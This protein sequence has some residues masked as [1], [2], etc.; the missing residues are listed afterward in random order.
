VVSSE[1]PTHYPLIKAS[2]AMSSSLN[3]P[4]EI[5]AQAGQSSGRESRGRAETLVKVS[6]TCLVTKSFAVGQT[7]CDET[8]RVEERHVPGMQDGPAL[9]EGGAPRPSCKPRT[10]PCGPKDSMLPSARRIR[11]GGWPALEKVRWPFGSTTAATR[12]HELSVHEK[13]CE[14]PD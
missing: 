14:I 7:K 1:C 5:L 3:P 13:H 4:F 2:A 9:I 6:S 12:R 11:S 8:I 10:V